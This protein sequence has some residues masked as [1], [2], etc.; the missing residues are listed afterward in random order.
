MNDDNRDLEKLVED[1]EKAKEALF[2]IDETE[3][4]RLSTIVAYLVSMFH[5]LMATL[6]VASK[7]WSVLLIIVFACVVLYIL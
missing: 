4:E 6:Y 2:E 1:V 7:C 5:I 3:G